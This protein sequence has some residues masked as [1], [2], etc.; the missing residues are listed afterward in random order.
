M[1]NPTVAAGGG[2]VSGP[3]A[4]QMLLEQRSLMQL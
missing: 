4:A 1:A 2:G 3:T